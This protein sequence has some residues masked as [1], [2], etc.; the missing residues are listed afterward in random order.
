MDAPTPLPTQPPLLPRPLQPAVPVAVQVADKIGEWIGV[1]AI[2]LLAEHHQIEGL[3]AVV[4]IGGLLG[5]NT[6][7]RQFGSRALG[8]VSGGSCLGVIGLGVGLAVGGPFAKA[9]LAGAWQAARMS[10]HAMFPVLM[11]FA[12]VG[13]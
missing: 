7:L 13:L 8:A 2:Y 5:V 11:S 12:S 9:I 3:L 6:G 1:V 10:G 4:A